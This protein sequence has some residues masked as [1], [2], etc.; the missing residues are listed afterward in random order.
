MEKEKPIKLGKIENDKASGMTKNATWA[1]NQTFAIIIRDYLKF[2][3]E[4]SPA[5]GNCVYS[6]EKREKTTVNS[7][8]ARKIND[9]KYKEWVDL[10]NR[11]ADEFDAL[12]KAIDGN[13]FDRE[14]PYEELEKMSKQAFE[15]LNK[16]YMD[17]WW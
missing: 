14:T 1:L 4:V 5:I 2:F 10:V 15:D 17:L 16:I 9:E 3:N 12:A 7:D 11:V 6:E 8:E 13:V